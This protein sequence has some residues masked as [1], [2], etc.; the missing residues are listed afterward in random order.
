MSNPIIP[1]IRANWT[2]IY[3]IVFGAIIGTY[4][5]LSFYKINFPA[6]YYDEV[7]YT[8]SI[9]NSCNKNG[10]NVLVLRFGGICFPILVMA[11]I[12]ALKSYF[13]ILF[14]NF[15]FVNSYVFFRGFSIV[16]GSISLFIM[17]GI[18]QILKFKK[19]ISLTLLLLIGLNS[20]YIFANKYDFGPVS[21]AILLKSLLILVAIKYFQTR[22]KKLIFLAVILTLLG[23]FNKIDFAFFLLTFSPFLLSSIS[24]RVSRLSPLSSRLF[25]LVSIFLV[26]SLFYLVSRISSLVSFLSS[27]FTASSNPLGTIWTLHNVL[28]GNAFSAV[29]TD[30][31]LQSNLEWVIYLGLLILLFLGIKF[32]SKYTKHEKL[33]YICTLLYFVIVLFFPKS[34]G[35]H[36]I[37]SMHPIP[38]ILIGIVL[39]KIQFKKLGVIL[40]GGFLAIYIAHNL[41]IYTKSIEMFKKDKVNVSWSKATEVLY[42]KLKKEYSNKI[43]Y[44]TDWG[45]SNQL[46]MYSKYNLD[47]REPFRPIRLLDNANHLESIRK[48]D[49]KNSVAVKFYSDVVLS[50]AI[51]SFPFSNYENSEIVDFMGIKRFI[52]YY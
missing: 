38:L 17:A 48:L 20:S 32:K 25:F 21:I 37:I 15:E 8:S 2:I 3:W 22:N 18:F 39:N 6:F 16:I 19:T 5:F 9:F 49:T 34:G 36:H 47:I 40:L 42:D 7:L 30:A 33:F 27:S 31:Y 1:K 4:L 26:S 24:F 51:D 50:P 44:T 43:I 29:I 12:G 45:I 46:I 13:F 23:T 35:P 28:I 11:Y 14:S 52:I 10:F 41:I